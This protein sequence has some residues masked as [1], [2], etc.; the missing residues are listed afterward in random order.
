MIGGFI[1]DPFD[2]VTEYVITNTEISV[3]LGVYAIEMLLITILYKV[4]ISV[5]EQRD[6]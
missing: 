1:P 4:A 6:K 3:T 5:R 2:R